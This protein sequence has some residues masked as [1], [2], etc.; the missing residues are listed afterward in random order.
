MRTMARTAVPALVVAVLALAPAVA[1]AA[2]GLVGTW[3]FDEPGGQQALDRGP[4]GLD[5][6][7]GRSEAPDDLDPARIAGARGGGALRFGG[8][9]FV[10]LPDAAELAPARLTVEAVVRAEGS[11]GRWRYIVARGAQDCLAG[12]YGL[13]SGEAG[14]LAFYAFDGDRY[15]LSPTARVADVWDGRWHHVA[16]VFDGLTVRLLVDGRPVGAPMAAPLA[17]AYGLTSRTTYLGT[18]EGTCAL[19][20]RGDVDLVRLWSAPLDDARLGELARAALGTTPA[21]A[22]GGPGLPPTPLTP[23]APGTT[24]AAPA[25]GAT[26]ARG[27]VRTAPG[28]P[29]RACRMTP[30]R[31]RL[32][33]GRRAVLGVTVRWRGR[34]VARAS[35][36]ARH[37][38]RGR[39]LARGRTSARG[40]ARLVLRPRRSGR[41]RLTVRGRPGCRADVVVRARR[42]RAR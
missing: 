16:G 39:V 34:A 23:A 5:G 26:G 13:Y 25:P 19:P 15:V 31:R 17:I 21:T 33:R 3:G 6:R 41:L 42:P 38:G 22:P 28:A 2:P 1:G 18:Y 14:G 9:T 11:P 7:L 4:F 35:V 12:S 37:Q 8:G 29:P 24:L 32:S 10:R 20:F 27:P 36:L 30:T 40:R